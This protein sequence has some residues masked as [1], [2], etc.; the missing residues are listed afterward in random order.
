MI[1]RAVLAA[2]ADAGDSHRFSAR[3]QI[4]R[5]IADAVTPD[6]AAF[7]GDI[8]CVGLTLTAFIW[9]TSIGT[10]LRQRDQARIRHLTFDLCTAVGASALGDVD[11]VLRTTI[12]TFPTRIASAAGRMRP[13][14]ALLTVPAEMAPGV[15]RR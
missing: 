11:V 3:R 13:G 6:P 15:P 9:I 5:R 14:D 10:T 7:R 12:D 2:F 8:G 4:V 1:D